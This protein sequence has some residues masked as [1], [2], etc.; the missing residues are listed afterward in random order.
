MN[1]LTA[2]ELAALAARI[3]AAHARCEQAI[4]EGLSHAKVAGELLLQAKRQCGA[5][6]GG[7]II[8]LTEPE[9]QERVAQTLR[10]YGGHV[11]AARV[12]REG[13][14]ISG[15]AFKSNFGV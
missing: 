15:K 3:N 7:C 6:G 13:L 14:T 5:G 11:L 9:S 8:F 12:A 2:N 1:D 4:S 10:S